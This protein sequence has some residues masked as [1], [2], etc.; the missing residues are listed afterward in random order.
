MFFYFQ[1][2]L[3]GFVQQI[4]LKNLKKQLKL[5]FKLKY[6]TMQCFIFF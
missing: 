4:T 1:F 2:K 3:K 6:F 5:S